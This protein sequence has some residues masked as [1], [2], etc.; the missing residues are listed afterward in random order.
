[1]AGLGEEDTELEPTAPEPGSIE[2]E[3]PPETE[4]DDDDSDDGESGPEPGPQPSQRQQRRRERAANYRQLAETTTRLQE[5]LAQ[6]R[7][8][9]ARMQ[10][11]IEAGLQQ[12]QP[13]GPHPLEQAVED[14]LRRQEEHFNYYAANGAKMTEQQ[15]ADAAR[16][17]RELEIE[18]SRALFALHGAQAGYQRVD[19]QMAEQQRFQIQVDARY[20]DIAANPRAA[21]V[22][23]A[24]LDR[25]LAEGKPFTW[26]TFDEAA[27]ETR[28][29]PALGLKPK[30]APSPT[31][32]Q[33]QQYAGSPKGPAAG[34]KETP[35]KITLTKGEVAMA[36]KMY[37]GLEPRQAH[38]KWYNEIGKKHKT[39]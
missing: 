14:V 37:P 36:E 10:G 26:E 11:L 32:R 27:E 33:R 39:A 17:A 4:D 3:L 19:P 30:G 6:E 2:L 13:Q 15:R 20:P 21:R 24:I 29:N 9:R 8:A 1:M 25:M 12:R 23:R 18:K 5:E 22:G 16:R 35:R 28:R 7:E 38:L 34:T 31:P